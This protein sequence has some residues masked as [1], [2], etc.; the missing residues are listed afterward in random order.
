[1]SDAS[2]SPSAAR[3]VARL[4]GLAV[5]AWAVAGLCLLP[6]VAVALAALLGG[7]ETVTEAKFVPRS[8]RPE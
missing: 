6:M 8:R 4:S 2:L 3:K 5:V 7:T 1:M